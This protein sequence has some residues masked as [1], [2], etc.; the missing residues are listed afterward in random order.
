MGLVDDAITQLTAAAQDEEWKA[1]SLVV[2]AGLRARLG[3]T[4]GAIMLLH[5][6]IEAATTE[7]EL[8]EARY[9]LSV[10]CEEIGD[11]VQAVELLEAVRTG[12]RDREERLSRLRIS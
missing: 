1:R 3:D 11:T 8:S 4:N 5:E 6:A 10:L 2:V 7:D 9:E 12:F